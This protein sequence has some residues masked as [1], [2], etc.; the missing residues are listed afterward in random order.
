[1]TSGVAAVLE[2]QVPPCVAL[3]LPGALLSREGRQRRPTLSRVA[4]RQQGPG[5]PE[6]RH[7]LSPPADPPLP[8]PTGRIPVACDKTDTSAPRPR[9]CHLRRS[10]REDLESVTHS[11]NPAAPETAKI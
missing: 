9:G 7:L 11:T 1:M 10:T 4:F 3:V 2:K 6:R 5:V 8:P